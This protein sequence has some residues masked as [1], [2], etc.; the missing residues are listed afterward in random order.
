L[1]KREMDDAKEELESLEQLFNAGV[2]TKDN[3]DRAKRRYED[4]KYDYEDKKKQT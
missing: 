1:P 4:A 3:V 2:E